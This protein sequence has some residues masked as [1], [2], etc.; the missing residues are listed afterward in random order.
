M[1]KKTQTKQ[2]RMMRMIIQTKRE[3][4]SG[5]TPAAGLAVSVDSTA[6]VETHDPDSEPV[7]DMTDN[8]DLHKH[9]ESSH[10]ADSTPCFD[11]ISEDNPEDELDLWV[12][13]ITRATCTANDLLAA[14]GITSWI[15]K[16]SQIYWRQASMIAN[17]STRLLDQ[18]CLPLEPSGPRDGN[19]TST[20]T[21]DQTGP[22]EN[23]DL[24][25]DM[26][27]LTTAEDSSKW[28]AMES[29]FIDT[30]ATV[31]STLVKNKKKQQLG[32][33]MTHSY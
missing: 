26:T 21:Y 33:L 29:D 6:D 1:N 18:T 8:Q 14:C 27:W 13:Y 22:T 23:N 19:M 12:D 20:S 32:C 17:H 16:Q 28:D 2:R 11:E 4:K 15:R 5:K 30:K 9:E 24:M 7:D 25:S 31:P 10:D 3:R